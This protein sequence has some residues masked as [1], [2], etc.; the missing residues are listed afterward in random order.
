MELVNLQILA[1]KG[2]NQPDREI[3]ALFNPNLIT[4]QKSVSW[5]NV[6]TRGSDVPGSQF[7]N[8]DP[9]VLT[10]EL[11]FDT[12]EAGSDVRKKTK[13]NRPPGARA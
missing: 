10:M 11:F 7:T 9:A 2:P 5:Q 4:I 8:G 12:Y 6:P 13:G 1:E 3:V